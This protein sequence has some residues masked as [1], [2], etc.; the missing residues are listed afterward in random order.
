M[1]FKEPRSKDE[2][3]IFQSYDEWI[4][5]TN[6][7]R[8]LD[9]LVDKIIN[10]NPEKF[11]WKGEST[12][13]CKSYSPSIML[14]LLLYGYLNN[15]P[16]SRRLE[17]E[18]YRNIELIW[19]LGELHPDHWTICSYRR[20]NKEQIRF[21]SLEFKKFLKSEG[22]I[23]GKTVA[24]DGSKFKAYTSREMLTVK[25]IERRLTKINEKVP[26]NMVFLQAD[27]LR[28]P[29]RENSFHTV[30]SQN[31]LHCLDDTSG[32]LKGLKNIMTEN[33]KMYFTTL[34]RGN[35]LADRY[36]QGL[37]SGGKLVARNIDQHR[38]VFEELGMSIKYDVNGNL[39]FIYYG[40]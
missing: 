27:A 35:R 31:L 9:L 19:L 30:I 36:L 17:R 24:I 2:I 26:G 10:A 6:P 32:L 12:I 29:F 33:G 18:S 5:K 16:G 34:V 20:E 23:D 28:L 11:T 15:L 38:A 22:Y 3:M 8:L 4:S 39:A 40:E 25:S 7:V 13:G 14:K 37:A 21:A 1:H